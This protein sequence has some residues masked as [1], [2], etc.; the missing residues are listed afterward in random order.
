M[1]LENLPNF[2]AAGLLA[3]TAANAAAQDAPMAHSGPG[4]NAVHVVVSPT[5]AVAVKTTNFR[6]LA[7][8]ISALK[9]QG[10]TPLTNYTPRKSSP[11]RLPNGLTTFHANL[12]SSMDRRLP[13]AVA[14]IP[15]ALS[16]QR[17]ELGPRT[18]VTPPPVGGFAGL[19]TADNLASFGYEF[20]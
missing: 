9:Q 11:H 16:V 8:K 19:S 14:A 17:P 20:E 7:G 10:V 15:Q 3:F 18:A 2:L 5:A 1:R 6:N 12:R 13:G 4:Q